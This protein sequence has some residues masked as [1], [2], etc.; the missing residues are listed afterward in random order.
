METLRN[1]KI[2]LENIYYYLHNNL[3]IIMKLQT[4]TS[5]YII[6]IAFM[7][8]KRVYSLPNTKTSLR[9]SITGTDK[10]KKLTTTLSPPKKQILTSIKP[11]LKVVRS[12]IISDISRTY[13]MTP[14]EISK[15]IN[16]Y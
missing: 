12:D 6:I 8:Y 3:K 15:C 13:K 9:G 16:L 2:E 1:N 11:A 14:L 5:F 10:C 7:L 4:L